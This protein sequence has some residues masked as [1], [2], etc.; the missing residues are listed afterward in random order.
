MLQSH[1]LLALMEEFSQSQM[2]NLPSNAAGNILDLV[3]TNSPETLSPIT[4]YSNVFKTDHTLLQCTLLFSHVFS[5]QLKRYVY[6]FKSADWSALKCMLTVEDLN[7]CTSNA[8]N[9]D[10]AWKYWLS[11][12]KG[13]LYKCVP[14]IVIRDSTS[15]PRIDKEVRGMYILKIKAWRKAKQSNKHSHWTSFRIL[16]NNYLNT[17]ITKYSRFIRGLSDSIRQDPKRY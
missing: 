11:F 3:F 13:A 17:I 15:P 7:N 5:G 10:E 8:G 6:N 4:E 9:V 16:R 12:V 14:K 2:N 1:V